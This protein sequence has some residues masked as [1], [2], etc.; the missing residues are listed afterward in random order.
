MKTKLLLIVAITTFVLF[1]DVPSLYGQGGTT[2]CWR[3]VSAGQNFTLAIK[4][5]GTL[6]GWGAN[7]NL[8]GL[9]YFSVSENLP[10]QIGTANDWF[11]VSAGGNHSLAVKTNGTLW[12]WGSGIFGQLGNGVF[13]SA[14]FN[15]TQV[16]T[17][18]DWIKVSAGSLFSV[19][20]KNN[21]TLWTWGRNAVGQL[22]NNTL[23]DTNVPAQVGTATDW[24]QIEAGNEHT[25]AIKT[26]G[27]LW[28]WGN[29]P[30]GQLG[31]GTATAS[32]NPIIISP[33]T[34]SAVS[35]GFDHSMALDVNGLLYTWGNNT[36]GQLCSGT[37][38][39]ANIPTLVVATSGAINFYFAI[40]AGQT[41]SMVLRTDNTLWTS[42]QN[43]SGQLGIG[44]NTNTNILNQV[45]TGTNWQL[46]SAGFVHS[47]A[48]EIGANLWSAGRGLEGQLGIGSNINSNIIVVVACPTPLSNE[49]IIGINNTFKLYPNPTNDFITIN[50]T[51]SFAEKGVIAITNMQGQVVQTF[52]FQNNT[53]QT[54]DVS[55]QS[56]GIYI[57][58]ISTKDQNYQ[59]KIIK[60]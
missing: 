49:E 58:S 40:S 44:N 33:A 55:N 56:S 21:G 57:L 53:I 22:G 9:G 31:N 50:T 2:S 16:G 23:L 6:W 19:A 38:T 3:E 4:A 13:N 24:S 30:F 37:N 18:T 7:A 45:G 20:L 36:N 25:L 28:S 35:A 27:T 60:Y 5:D 51:T 1:G 10:I 54:I 52:P 32:N 8:L 14:T 34:W 11:T 39:A 47:E 59:T 48:M 42:G 15:V 17:A 26:T 43:S 46:I 41:H 12:S 29:N